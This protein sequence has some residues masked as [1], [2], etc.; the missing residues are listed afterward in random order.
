MGRFARLGRARRPSHKKMLSVLHSIENRYIAAILTRMTYKD[1]DGDLS[2][3]YQ[4][5][6]AFD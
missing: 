6:V 1:R 4:I 5:I 3:L 2:R